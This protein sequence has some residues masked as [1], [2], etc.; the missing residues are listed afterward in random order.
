MLCAVNC[1]SSLPPPA[2]AFVSLIRSKFPL[3][4]CSN[5]IRHLNL[6]VGVVSYTS[7]RCFFFSLE[8]LNFECFH[9]VWMIGVR[10]LLFYIDFTCIIQSNVH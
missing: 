8:Y 10:T 3:L 2:S 7:L 1:F 6:S 4:F 5:S 9:A